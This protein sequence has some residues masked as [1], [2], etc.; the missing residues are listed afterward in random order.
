MDISDINEDSVSS[1]FRK[2]VD[3]SK[4]LLSVVQA[5]EEEKEEIA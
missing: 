2:R 5:I 3:F 1:N 4:D